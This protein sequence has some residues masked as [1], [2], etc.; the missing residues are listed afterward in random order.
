MRSPTDQPTDYHIHPSIDW[1]AVQTCAVHLRDLDRV[2]PPPPGNS[3]THGG[4]QRSAGGID[5]L[6]KETRTRRDGE[7]SAPVSLGWFYV[8]KFFSFFSFPSGG[9]GGKVKR[10]RAPH[11]TVLTFPP[12]RLAATHV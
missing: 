3:I 5:A 1:T 6:R 4:G 8:F 11:T 10:D 9:G 2:P 12:S 7:S